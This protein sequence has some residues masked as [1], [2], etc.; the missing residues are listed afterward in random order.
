MRK[1]N[2]YIVIYNHSFPRFSFLLR[3]NNDSTAAIFV[4]MMI[5]LVVHVKQIFSSPTD[6]SRSSAPLLTNNSG[7]SNMH[8]VHYATSDV[9]NLFPVYGGSSSS[10][11]TFHR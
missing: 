8:S 9:T 4:A 11:G 10:N 1:L 3:R 5:L 7:T 2:F 6:C